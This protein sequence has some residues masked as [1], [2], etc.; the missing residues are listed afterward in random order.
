VS[1][2][3]VRPSTDDD[4]EAILDVAHR[5]Y[6]RGTGRRAHWTAE[7]MARM[8]RLPT[9]DPAAD[10]PVVVRGE[11][12][13]AW[14]GVFANAPYTEIFTDLHVDPDLTDDDAALATAATTAAP[15]PSTRTP[16]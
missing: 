11:R 4:V 14:A 6:L 2:L 10:F 9:R 16:A 8:R 1:D 3:E 13:I 7:G 5:A 12:V 15:S